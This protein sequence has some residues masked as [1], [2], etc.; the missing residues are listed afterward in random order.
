MQSGVV[1]RES[2]GARGNGFEADQRTC[3]RRLAVLS[4]IY[5]DTADVGT[6]RLWRAA[7]TLAGRCQFSTLRFSTLVN[8]RMLSV[9]RMR[10]RDNACA[11]ISMS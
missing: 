8:S 1:E 4:L 2:D 6:Q 7:Q 3:Q 11:A 5:I 9:T 10:L